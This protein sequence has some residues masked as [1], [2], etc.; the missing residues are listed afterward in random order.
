MK[1]RHAK[2]E[3]AEEI[4]DVALKSWK[5]TYSQIFSEETIE[6]VISDWYGVE[7]LR[8]QAEHPIFYVAEADAQVIGFVHASVDDGK[9]TLHRIYLDSEYQ[10]EGIGSKLFRKA[11]NKIEQE[12]DSIEL[13]VLAENDKGTGFYLK[14]GFE[15][16]ETEEVELKGEKAEQKIL[17]KHF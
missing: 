2:Q 9:A 7:D 10:G 6:Q 17:V 3:D 16:Q 13:E 5:D 14:H 8:E 4:H 12:A 1:I 15:E 11:E